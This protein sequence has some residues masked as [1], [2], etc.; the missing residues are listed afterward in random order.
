MY[1]FIDSIDKRLGG[2]GD[3]IGVGRESIVAVAVVFNRH[4]P[5]RYHFGALVDLPV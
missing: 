3:N 5:F 4:M 2:C 1:K